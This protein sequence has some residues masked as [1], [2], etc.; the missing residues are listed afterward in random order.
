MQ[1]VNKTI[2]LRT[3]KEYCENNIEKIKVTDKLYR[4]NNKEKIKKA[5]KLYS[6]NN[7][8]KIKDTK[9][10]YYEKNKNVI[11]E[12]RKQKKLLACETLDKD[13]TIISSIRSIASIS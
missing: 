7:I 3:R 12:K 11:A 10:L 13:Q 8:E 9:K 6:E 4:E 2:P 5:K 1:C